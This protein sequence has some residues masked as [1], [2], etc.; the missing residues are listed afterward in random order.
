MPTP[1]EALEQIKKLSQN[2]TLRQKV[3]AASVVALAFAVF[4]VIFFIANRPV[5]KPLYSDL[6]PQDAAEIT[7]WLKKESVPYQLYNDGTAIRVPEEKIYDVR[8]SL[9]GAGLPRGSVGF[10]IFD[11]TN[12]GVTDFVQHVNYQRALQGELE[13]TISRF[14]QIRS[15]RVLLALPQESLFTSEKKEPTASVVLQLKPGE[16]L[17]RNQIKGIVHLVASAVPRLKKENVSV[18]DTDGGVLYDSKDQENDQ[19]LMTNTQLAYQKKL[20]DYY[21]H[22]IQSML[23]DVLGPNKAVV[24][25]ATDV[26]FDQVQT[27]EDRYD[28]DQTAVR[29][30]QKI[31]EIDT[32]QENAGGVA[33]VKGGL[34]DKLQGNVTGPAATN[35]GAGGAPPALIRQKTQDTSNY[36]ITRIQRQINASIGKLKKISVAVMVDGSYLPKGKELVYTPRSQEELA[37]LDRIVKAA[38]GFDPKRGDEVSVVNVPFKAQQPEGKAP[39]K[40]FELASYFATPFMNIILAV[41]FIV[42]VLRPL[43]NRYVLKPRGKEEAGAVPSGARTGEGETGEGEFEFPPPPVIH[44]IPDA[45]E[46]LREMANAYPE[47]AAALVKIWLREKAE[48]GGTKNA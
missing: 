31:S 9:A 30:E 33:G 29:S 28:P 34:A 17:S 1:Q 46:R 25:V 10:E 19:S 8:L 15:V 47:R 2:L 13:K 43:F 11:L 44:P 20:E 4:G 24:R 48:A 41:L 5:Y 35:T 37:N 36:E 26:D 32:S 14:P 18:V 42:F 16:E 45:R 27:S 23:E 22:K 21:R 7:A 40:L 39:S 12:L 6:S 38:I 3:V